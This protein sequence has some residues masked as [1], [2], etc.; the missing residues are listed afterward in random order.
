M[1]RIHRQI[2]CLL[3]VTWPTSRS[4]CG[5]GDLEWVGLQVLNWGAFNHDTSHAPQLRDL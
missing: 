5:R 3:V 1:I 4:K 2:S